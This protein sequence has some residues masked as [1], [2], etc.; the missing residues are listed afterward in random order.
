MATE[1][2]SGAVICLS[3]GKSPKSLSG[4]SRKNIPLRALLETALPGASGVTVVTNA[5]VTYTTRAAAGA[6]A[7][8]IASTL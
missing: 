1:P 4:P 3:T 7:P 6:S 5:R 8:G 2:P